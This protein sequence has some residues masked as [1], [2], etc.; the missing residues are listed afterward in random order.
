MSVSGEPGRAYRIR[1]HVRTTIRATL[2]NCLCN[3]VRYTK[4]ARAALGLALASPLYASLVQSTRRPSPSARELEAAD[5]RSPV[6]DGLASWLASRQEAERVGTASPSGLCRR[7]RATAASVGDPTRARSTVRPSG[8][9]ASALAAASHA[10][11]PMNLPKH[12]PKCLRQL[13]NAASC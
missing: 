2:N 4:G 13:V 7:C 11:R 6:L 3:R 10:H 8:R 9:R 5:A 1:T 12:Q